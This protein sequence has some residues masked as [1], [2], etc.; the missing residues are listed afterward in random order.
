MPCG[1]ALNFDVPIAMN[2]VPRT[3]RISQPRTSRRSSGDPR[4]EN[5]ARS[6]VV[7]S[8][9]SKR[10]RW[11]GAL[12]AHR[13]D[14]RRHERDAEQDKAR[15]AERE[16]VDRTHAEDQC[17]ERARRSQ[18]HDEADDETAARDRERVAS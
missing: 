2:S 10:D 9:R 17:A 11:I 13:W 5:G 15:G 1:S 3:A 16:T 14:I 8:L 4:I 6:I 12:R 18:R 7:M